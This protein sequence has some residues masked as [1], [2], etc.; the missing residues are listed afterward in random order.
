MFQKMIA[1][2]KRLVVGD[3]KPTIATI[4]GIIIGICLTVIAACGSVLRKAIVDEKSVSDPATH[5]AA[6]VTRDGVIVAIGVLCLIILIGTIVLTI[7]K[8]M[9]AIAKQRAIKRRYDAL[10]AQAVPSCR[11]DGKHEVISIEE[12]KRHRRPA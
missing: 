10:N 5:I 4:F 8:F 7:A 9:T 12:R 3:W 2:V 11:D 1:F 6:I